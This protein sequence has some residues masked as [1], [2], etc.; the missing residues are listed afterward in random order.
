MRLLVD[1]VSKAAK[2]SFGPD[3]KFDTAKFVR[4]V[5]ESLGSKLEE[6]KKWVNPDK[7]L[8]ELVELIAKI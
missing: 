6:L 8:E 3:G 1:I 5:R 4:L 2:E 7:W